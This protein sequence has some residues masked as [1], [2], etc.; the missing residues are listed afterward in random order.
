MDRLTLRIATEGAASLSPIAELRHDPIVD[1]V[2]PER[3]TD[4]IDRKA[5]RQLIK[6]SGAIIIDPGA[7][8]CSIE[9]PTERRAV[10]A[11]RARHYAAWRSF[12]SF[13][14]AILRLSRER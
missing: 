4:E 9:K 8:Q 5:D 14:N 12:L 1:V 11:D 7:H 6:T 10:E 3:E 13:F 2:K